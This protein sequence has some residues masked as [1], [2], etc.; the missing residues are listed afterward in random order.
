[1]KTIRLDDLPAVHTADSRWKPVR[2]TLGIRAFGINAYEA[3]APGDVVFPEHDETEALAGR[4]RHQELYVVLTGEARF[5]VDGEEVEARPGTLVFVA[6]PAARRAAVAL[7]PRTTVLAVGA[8][9]GEPYEPA[10]WERM[11]LERY[12]KATA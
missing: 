8:P 12:A 5:T 2:S 1:V 11:F 7:A 10:P 3:L 9:V 4:Q 6:D